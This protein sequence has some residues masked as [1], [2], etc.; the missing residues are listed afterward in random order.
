MISFRGH[1]ARPSVE[2]GRGYTKAPESGRDKET[3]GR[4]RRPRYDGFDRLLFL[5]T[6]LAVN[7]LGLI[8]KCTVH[9]VKFVSFMICFT[10]LNVVLI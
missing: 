7:Q 9:N 4:P 8:A 3:L 10:I 2:S 6:S 1:Y 5:N